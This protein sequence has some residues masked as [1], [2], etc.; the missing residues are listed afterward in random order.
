MSIL[1]GIP[2]LLALHMLQLAV[3]G[4]LPLLSGRADLV[5]LVLIAW[6]LQ[7]RVSSAVEW[8]VIAGLM[9]GLITRLPFFVPLAGYLGVTLLARSL[10]RRVW[11]TPFL[12]M[13]VT[14]FI[15]TMLYHGLSWLILTL[16]GTSLPIVDSLNLV[17]LPATLLNLIL[18]LPV[19]ALVSDLVQ[20]LYPEE[21]SA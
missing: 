7:D 20:S 9:S 21:V 18:A 4:M 3:V 17:I 11:Q 13:F 1:I 8:A 2:I 16:Q 5:L 14:T 6:A 15:G 12:A 10:S 19:Y